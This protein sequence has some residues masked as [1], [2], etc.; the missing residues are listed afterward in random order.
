M[1]QMLLTMGKLLSVA[2]DFQPEAN[3]MDTTASSITS[4]LH[5][6]QTDTHYIL[7][8]TDDSVKSMSKPLFVSTSFEHRMLHG[9]RKQHA[10]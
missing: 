5:P 9:H 7:Q 4:I 10:S 6:S 1:L 3:I 2:L 8:M